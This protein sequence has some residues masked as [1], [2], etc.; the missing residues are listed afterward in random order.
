MLVKNILNLR[1]NDRFSDNDLIDLS[2]K[3]NLTA[4]S[5]EANQKITDNAMTGLTNLVELDLSYNGKITDNGLSCLYNLTK[6]NLTCNHTIT[7]ASVAKLTNL[8]LLNLDRTNSVS[9]RALQTLPALRTVY[10]KHNT[11]LA[12]S[13]KEPR[14]FSVNF[15]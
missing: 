6:L 13:L 7:G 8:T 11:L 15:I 9:L 2:S 4:L 3:I 10:T 12:K 1:E 5:L 14:N